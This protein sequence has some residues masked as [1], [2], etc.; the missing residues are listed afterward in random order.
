MFLSPNVNDTSSVT[1]PVHESVAE[2]PS[3]MN[4]FSAVVHDRVVDGK[5][6]TVSW[7]TGRTPTVFVTDPHNPRCLS[8]PGQIRSA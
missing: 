4:L 6:D 2:D 1:F 3:S 8:L 5:A 7:E